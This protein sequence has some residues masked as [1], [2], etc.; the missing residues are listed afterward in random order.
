MV[1]FTMIF[2]R[3]F[4]CGCPVDIGRSSSDC[5]LT[6]LSGTLVA[7][8]FSETF[9]GAGEFQTPFSQRCQTLSVLTSHG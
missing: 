4:L 6:K 7:P 9:F 3:E 8:Y 5:L 2:V 1:V